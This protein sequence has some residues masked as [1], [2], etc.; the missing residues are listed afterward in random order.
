MAKITMQTVFWTYLLQKF[1]LTCVVILCF[2]FWIS[3]TYLLTYCCTPGTGMNEWTKSYDNACTLKTI[4]HSTGTNN[5]VNRLSCCGQLCSN[6]S[7]AQDCICTCNFVVN[8]NH[9]LWHFNPRVGLVIPF[10]ECWMSRLDSF[11]NW[12]LE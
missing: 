6:F 8:E 10:M 4:Q 12:G 7:V 9:V 11:F 2:W 1:T 3:A 5:Q